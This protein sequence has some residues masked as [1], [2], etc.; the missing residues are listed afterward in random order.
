MSLSFARALILLTATA[1]SATLATSAQAQRAPTPPTDKIAADLGVS[2]PALKTCFGPVPSAEN[3]APSGP[4]PQMDKSGLLSCLQG[5]NPG[6]TDA[7]LDAV[8]EKYR[9]EGR[10]GG[11]KG[12]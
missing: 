12:G 11:K 6:L 4:P 9:P 10:N 8:M 1:T 2:E 7:K 3:K 5:A